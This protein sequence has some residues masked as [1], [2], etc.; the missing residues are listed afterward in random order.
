MSSSTTGGPSGQ[1]LGTM[2]RAVLLRPDLWLTAVTTLVRLAPTGWWRASPRRPWPDGRLW[3]FRMVTAYGDPSE[4]PH[5]RDVISYLEWCRSTGAASR[6][7]PRF[8]GLRSV[9][10]RTT[11]FDPAGED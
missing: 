3:A 7:G 6:S 8:S 2:A 10:T 9:A 4:P 1:V 11:R 5:R